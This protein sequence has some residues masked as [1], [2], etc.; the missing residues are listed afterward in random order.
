MTGLAQKRKTRAR[1]PVPAYVIVLSAVLDNTTLEAKEITLFSEL[2]EPMEMEI[3][4]FQWSSR[5]YRQEILAH[6]GITNSR[7]ITDK[8]V[9]ILASMG[10]I[11]ITYYTSYVSP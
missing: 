1:F 11:C 8:R 10:L 3:E 2:G 5:R 4:S 9:I 7:G 6:S